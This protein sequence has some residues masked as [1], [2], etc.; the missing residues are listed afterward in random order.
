MRLPVGLLHHR[1]EVDGAVAAADARLDGRQEVL[2]AASAA[3]EP[4]EHQHA[5]HDDQRDDDD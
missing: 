2:E 4:T 5:D 1:H 3:R